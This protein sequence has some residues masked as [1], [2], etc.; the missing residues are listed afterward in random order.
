MNPL[1]GISWLSS[2]RR[3]REAA[4]PRE[5]DL[6]D[7]GTTFGLDAAFPSLTDESRQ[8]IKTRDAAD[9]AQPADLRPTR[10]M[11]Y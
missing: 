4:H 8:E 7:M 3:R 6:A 11:R 2:L 10:P 9:A 5:A 1:S